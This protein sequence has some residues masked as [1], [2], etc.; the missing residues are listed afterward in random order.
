MY[1]KYIRHF[2]KLQQNPNT[3]PTD[4]TWVAQSQSAC[5]SLKRANAAFHCAA[6]LEGETG[7]ELDPKLNPTHKSAS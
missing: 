6:A 1:F 3:N 7:S 2:Y 4:R 5:I